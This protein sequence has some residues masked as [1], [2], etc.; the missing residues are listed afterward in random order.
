M[1][2]RAKLRNARLRAGAGL[3]RLGSATRRAVP[4]RSFGAFDEPIEA[5]PTTVPV[6]GWTYDPS[7]TTLAVI[8]TIDGHPAAAAETGILREDIFRIRRSE[9]SARSGFSAVVDLSAQAGRTVALGAFLIRQNGI[10]DSLPELRLVVGAAST[11]SA[12]FHAGIVSREAPV[13]A[14]GSFDQPADGEEVKGD[15]LYVWGGVVFPGGHTARIHVELDGVSIGLARPFVNHGDAELRYQHVDAPVAGYEGLF[16]LDAIPRPSDVVVTVR[17]ES[18]DG[19][20]WHSQPVRIVLPERDLHEGA[21]RGLVLRQRTD[22]LVANIPPA[23]R[24]GVLVFTHDLQLGGGQL[25]LWD[26]IRQ[27]HAQPDLRCS[28]VAPADGPLRARLEKLGIDV[29]I[30]A[31]WRLLSP[32]DYEGRVRELALLAR[33]IGCSSVFVNTLGMFAAADAV[34]RLGVPTVWAIHE[35]YVT[36]VFLY[37]AMSRVIDPYVR[38]RLEHTLSSASALV[39]EARDTSELFAPYLPETKRFV[40]EYGIDIDAIDE[41]RAAFDR[42]K[43]RE[44]VGL[45][46][47]DTIVLVM[48]VFEP[49]KAQAVVV[50]AFDEL[51]AVHPEVKLVLVGAHPIEYTRAVEE[52]IRRAGLTDRVLVVPITPDIY[53]W[54]ALSDLFL[55]PSDI[56]SLPRSVLEAMAFEVPILATAVWGLNDLIRDGENGWLCAPRDLESLV[57]ALH[58]VLSLDC[59]EWEQV[60]AAGRKHVI[61]HHAVE[62]YAQSIGRALRA[63]ADDSDAD[64]RSAFD[65]AEPRASV[66]R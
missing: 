56:E 34:Q 24:G 17:A 50:A 42:K 52:Q 54:Y 27:I 37:I 21:D 36:S 25:W 48:G 3:R 59:A 58:R 4:R 65:V 26:L 28:V 23:D 29:H 61:A 15:V 46:V 40:V 63:L 55:C 14:F 41:F 44:R 51:A 43:A 53:E 9:A 47:D 64:L 12:N 13:G 11:V 49:R 57:G 45:S 60:A 10:V 66:A 16:A 20:T 7:L 62:G 22:G 8:I 18:F 35:S 2:L 1:T 5:L 31:P 38:G 19:R 39:F 32:D 6:T 30:T 33:S